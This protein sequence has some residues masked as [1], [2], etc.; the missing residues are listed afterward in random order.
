M[1]SLSFRNLLEAL[2][3]ALRLW[4]RRSVPPPGGLAPDSSFLLMRTLR[5][6]SEGAT[7]DETCTGF[8][9]PGS[10]LAQAWPLWAF[11]E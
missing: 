2:T 10:S 1:Y 4:G 6:G 11:G 7:Y 8:P 9:A 3:A 5:D